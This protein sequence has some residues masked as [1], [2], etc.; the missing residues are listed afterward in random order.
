[1]T[2]TKAH[3]L[4]VSIKAKLSPY[5]SRCEIAGSIRRRCQE[6]GDV[7]IVC[8]PLKE[9]DGLFDDIMV[10]NRG[11]I[12]AVNQWEKVRGNPEGSYTQRIIDGEKL[13]IFI[14]NEN[15]WGLIYAVRTGSR[16]FSHYKLASRWK[17]LGYESKHGVLW[18]DDEPTYVREEKDLFKLLGRD[19][20]EPED[21]DE[22]FNPPPH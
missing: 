8:V 17:K 18:K 12:Q 7:E 6:V 9:K 13:D 2:F 16:D 4:A 1:M 10:V 20:V 11:F 21:R 19:W 5:C 14:A 3:A 15:N 22:R